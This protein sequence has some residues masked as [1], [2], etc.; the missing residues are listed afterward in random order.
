MK[1]YYQ[2]DYVTIYHGDCL[3]VLPELQ[4]VDLVLTDPPYGITRQPWDTVPDWSEMGVLLTRAVGP[5]SQLFL[6]GMQP[7]F[8]D[9]I[10]GLRPYLHFKDEI[11][12]HYKDGGAGNTKGTG[13]KNVHQNLAWFSA[14]KDGYQF[15]IDEIRIAYQPN[16]RNQY[17]VKR[18]NR[19]WTPNPNGA[20]PTN[21]F[22]C[23]KHKEIERGRTQ[24]HEHYTI[25]PV[26]L[27]RRIVRGFS[28]AG[29][30]VLDPYLGTGTTA[31]A[32]KALNRKCIGI[33]M[34]EKYCEIAA[35][36]CRQTVMELGV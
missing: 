30:V 29:S 21:I 36:R 14:T 34:G 9:M 11:I 3:E 20:Y 6:F 33:E 1:P 27:L 26:A 16:A 32:A 10:V 22:E 17:P 8:S 2:D 5:E 15:N 28:A 24:F 7:T 18:G 13:L 4:K 19:I 12:W 25:K 35:N 31:V 23:P